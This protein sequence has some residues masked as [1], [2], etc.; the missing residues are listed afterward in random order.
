[1]AT[2]L[3]DGVLYREHLEHARLVCRDAYRRNHD[4]LVEEL[5]ADLYQLSAHIHAAAYRWLRAFQASALGYR[6]K[7][8]S[9]GFS[10][11]RMAARSCR[12]AAAVQHIMD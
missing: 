1:M 2:D 8:A 3:K 5:E 6:R 4:A 7:P 9:T 12:A 10:R 11:M